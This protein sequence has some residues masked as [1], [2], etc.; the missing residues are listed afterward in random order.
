MH[1]LF[2]HNEAT[3]QSP[4]YSHITGYTTVTVATNTLQSSQLFHSIT[5]D[6]WCAECLTQVHGDGKSGSAQP[7]EHLVALQINSHVSN[8][9]RSLC[10]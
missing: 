1:L 8:V 3:L 4:S 5:L 9:K 7:E 6:P 2:T 10:T